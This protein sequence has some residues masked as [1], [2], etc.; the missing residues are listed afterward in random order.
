MIVALAVRVTRWL[1]LVPDYKLAFRALEQPI[2]RGEGK[3][4]RA[5][6]RRVPC[7]AAPGSEVSE[8]EKR[9]LV[10]VWVFKGIK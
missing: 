8:E 4:R 6:P 5:L 1:L 3:P 7:G 10:C 9:I 2:T